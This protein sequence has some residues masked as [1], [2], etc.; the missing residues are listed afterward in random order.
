MLEEHCF[1]IIDG[2][3]GSPTRNQERQVGRDL[4]PCVYSVL[5]LPLGA[6]L[7]CWFLIC[8]MKHYYLIIVFVLEVDWPHTHTPHDLKVWEMLS[9]LGHYTSVN[10]TT[11]ET[12]GPSWVKRLTQ[13]C[14]T[15]KMTLLLQCDQ[16]KSTKIN[17]FEAH[18]FHKT[19]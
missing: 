4:G 12:P 9:D 3:Q 1:R 17:V 15:G 19:M 7:N 18:L 10:Y 14:S 11:W 2:F 5:D 13:L 8:R 6:T 16:S